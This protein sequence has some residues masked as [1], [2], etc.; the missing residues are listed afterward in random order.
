MA[1]NREA[2]SITAPATSANLGPGF[3]VLALALDLANEVRVVRRPGPLTVVVEGEGA[4]EA[5]LDASNLVC[6]ALSEGIG[7]LDGLQITCRN[8]IPF[9]RGLGSSAAAVCSGLVA[10]NALG[11][12]RWSPS[13]ILARAIALE[14]HGD[15]AAACLDGGITALVPGPRSLRIPPPDGLALVVVIPDVRVSTPEA[16]SLMPS[17]VPIADAAHNLAATSGLVLTLERGRVDEIPEFLMD[18]LHEPYRAAL[19]PGIDR[20]KAVEHPGLLGVTVSG[21]GPSMLMWVMS[22]A[23]S[24]IAAAARATLDQGAVRAE[25]RVER[26]AS[27]GVRARW[28]G[29]E[30]TVLARTP[31]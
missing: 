30:G 5:P 1:A 23:A 19:C 16:R 27:A 24:E 2:L 6:R 20:L 22:D 29:T 26:I 9:G 17:Q 21:S 31:G 28:E 14:G 3:D 13:D 18:R 7:D 11:N 25:V 10:A 4:G 15:N 12:L 8:R